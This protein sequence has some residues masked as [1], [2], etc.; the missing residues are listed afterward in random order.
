MIHR[1][2]KCGDSSGNCPRSLTKEIATDKGWTCPC[3]NPRCVELREEVPWFRAIASRHKRGLVIASLAVAVLLI[4]AL[5]VVLG[6]ENLAGKISPLR[7]HLAGLDKKLDQLQSLPAPASPIAEQTLQARLLQQRAAETSTK[8]SAAIAA[9]ASQQ[10]EDLRKEVENLRAALD[11]LSKAVAAGSPDSGSLGV[12]ANQLAGNYEDLEGQLVAVSDQINQ[13]GAALS[14]KAEAVLTDIG[15]LVSRTKDGASKARKLVKQKSSGPR[16]TKELA[17]SLD[18]TRTLLT[19]LQA[20]LK[21]YAPPPP[22]PFDPKEATLRITTTA[23]LATTLLQPLLESWGE[24]KCIA[25]PGG[26]GFLNSTKRSQKI[27]VEV[28]R[29]EEAFDRLAKSGTDL[30][31]I[32]RDPDAKERDVLGPGFGTD[33]S[34]AEVVAMDALTLFVHRANPLDI[35]EVGKKVPLTFLSG[36]KD[37]SSYRHAMQFGFQ[38]DKESAQLA[39]DAA[40]GDK[41]ILALGLYHQEEGPLIKAK[42]LEVKPSAS[43][44]PLKPGPFTIATEDY[45]YSFRIVAWNLPQP[46]PAA[47]E[48]VRFVTSDAGQ[49]IV[50]KQH[51]VDL[52]LRVDP[53]VDPRILAALGSALGV[54]KIQSAARL[55]TNFRFEVGK[56]DFD[57]KAQADLERLPRYL[58]SAYPTHKVVVLGFTDNTGSASR[59]LTLSKDRARVVADKLTGFKVDTSIGGL[60]CDFPIDT[61]ATEAGRARNR[62]AEVWVAKP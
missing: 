34:T 9:K 4:A 61:D 13:S 47:L 44:M 60:G 57:L 59:H 53:S 42:R 30:L 17:G 46:K 32:D 12:E 39:A 40:V 22:M 21:A 14:P 2:F 15:D 3:S 31:L 43:S 33:Q 28:V 56:S 23:E 29:A 27:L 58:A 1:Y 24:A 50:E 62:R 7:E 35:Y 16:D 41:D 10:I 11:Q 54:S 6:G 52:R 8:V 51:Y 18:G 25:G 49:E 26:L 55:S 5:I 45:L 37:S 48:F 38:V 36:L 19:K 20:D